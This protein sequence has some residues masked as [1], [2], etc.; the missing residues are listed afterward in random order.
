MQPPLKLD[1]DIYLRK[2]RR[3]IVVSDTLTDTGALNIDRN[4]SGSNVMRAAGIFDCARK[5]LGG[6]ERNVRYSVYLDYDQPV[7]PPWQENL[8]FNGPNQPASVW[9][10]DGGAILKLFAE[11]K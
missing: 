10:E 6:P 9:E 7:P 5:S 4:Q 3:H 1:C 11:Q 8:K 2:R